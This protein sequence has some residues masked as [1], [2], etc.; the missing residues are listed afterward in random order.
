MIDEVTMVGGITAGLIIL[1][2][3]A[4]MLRELRRPRRHPVRRIAANI[5]KR[6]DLVRK[7]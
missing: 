5:A 2:C 7:P 3:L 4:Y 6:P 1:F